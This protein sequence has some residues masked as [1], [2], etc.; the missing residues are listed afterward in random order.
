MYK[1]YKYKGQKLSI[2]TKVNY[3]IRADFFVCTVYVFWLAGVEA[4]GSYFEKKSYHP[5]SPWCRLNN[6]VNRREVWDSWKNW[7]S[8]D[9]KWNGQFPQDWKIGRNR[10]FECN[11]FFRFFVCCKETCSHNFHLRY[12]F[13]PFCFL[14]VCVCFFYFPGFSIPS[15]INLLSIVQGILDFPI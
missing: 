1:E 11:I 14:C 5:S 7:K 3:V 2:R 6:T 8:M 4:E 10:Y 9:F 12:R 13:W 15:E